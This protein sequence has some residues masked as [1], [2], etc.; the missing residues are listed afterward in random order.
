MVHQK[1]YIDR[2]NGMAL[3]QVSPGS[4]VTIVTTVPSFTYR[5]YVTTVSSV[6]L[7]TI[8]ITVYTVSYITNVTTGPNVTYFTMFKMFLASLHLCHHSS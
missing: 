6:T 5:P 8:V 3:Y 2:F 4:C 7:K 1:P